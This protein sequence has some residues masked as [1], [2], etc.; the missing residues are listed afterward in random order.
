M[1]LRVSQPALTLIEIVESIQ[2]K[3]LGETLPKIYGGSWEIVSVY[4][5]LEKLCKMV[6]F[7][8]TVSFAGDRH[9][10]YKIMQEALELFTKV[11]T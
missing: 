2:N 1:S 3:T 9:K 11:R 5:S 6:R 8:N 7:S 10:S 4:D